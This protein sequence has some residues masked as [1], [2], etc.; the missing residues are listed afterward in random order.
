MKRKR[1]ANVDVEVEEEE[2]EE[3]GDEH[4]DDNDDGLIKSEDDTCGGGGGGGW[5]TSRRRRNYCTVGLNL[6]EVLPE[7]IF[8]D[9]ILAIVLDYCGPPTVYVVSW[10][11]ETDN[12][13][14]YQEA[15]HEVVGAYPTRTLAAVAALNHMDLSSVFSHYRRL[16]KTKASKLVHA[17]KRSDDHEDFVKRLS[18]EDQELL[19]D[20]I[21]NDV[22]DRRGTLHAPE[23]WY[24]IHSFKL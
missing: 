6:R 7:E 5:V 11:R 21:S 18:D 24:E 3:D 1:D 19:F 10:S 17:L 9:P 8:S 20:E 12:H 13:R 2:E 15:E 16:P 23:P 22:F 14:D 4:D